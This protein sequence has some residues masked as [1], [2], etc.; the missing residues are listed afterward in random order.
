MR[1]GIPTLLLLPSLVLAVPPGT[2]MSDFGPSQV[3]LGLFFDHS[4]QDVFQEAAPSV[5]NTTGLSIE[6]APWPYLAVGA[7]GGAA[8]FDVDVPEGSID[9][10]L[11]Y[12]TGFSFYG[13]GSLKLATPRFLSGTTRLVAQATAGYL[14]AEDDFGNVKAGIMTNSGASAQ[15]LAWGRLNLVLGGEFQA[16]LRGEQT[17]SLE[18]TPRIF[19]ISEPVGVMDYLRGLAGIEYYFNARNRP[20]VSV[21]IRPTGA[22]GWHDH[23]GLRN[24]SISVTLG[25]IATLPK[26][27]KNEVNEEEPGLEED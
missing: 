23:L 19:G 25:A 14:R 17:S 20:F 11:G 1:T 9:S 24:G 7:F 2:P 27:G 18:K 12:N 5:L 6:Y 15:V 4:G 13:G 22:S 10:S 26:K 8:E 21:A 3:S 16:L